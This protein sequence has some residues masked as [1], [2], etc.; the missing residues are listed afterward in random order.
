MNSSIFSYTEGLL[1]RD[2]GGLLSCCRYK[3]HAP[4]YV[5]LAGC[6]DNDG[7]SCFVLVYNPKT[8]NKSYQA[9]T[10]TPT[11]KHNTQEARQC[12]PASPPSAIVPPVRCPYAHEVVQVTGFLSIVLSDFQH[13]LLTFP[14]RSHCFAEPRPLD[15]GII[16]PSTQNTLGTKSDLL[17][18]KCSPNS[19]CL[20]C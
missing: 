12:A 7:V 4:T 3:K 17:A 20:C 15:G 11:I 5:A 9:K 18:V 10:M 8:D 19:L 6:D 2:R 14:R 1:V 16:S 13:F